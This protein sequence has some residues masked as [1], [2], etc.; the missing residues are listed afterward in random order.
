MR[1]SIGTVHLSVEASNPGGNM[2]IRLV[3]TAVSAV[4]VLVVILGTVS[5]LYAYTVIDQMIYP[6]DG[7]DDEAPGKLLQ[8]PAGSDFQV[9]LDSILASGALGLPGEAVQ[10]V[11]SITYTG[12]DAVRD[13]AVTT[14]LHE[15]LRVDAVEATRGEVSVSGP[16]VVVTAAKLNPGDV[17]AF[18]VDTT[19]LRSP[20]NGRLFN[21]TVLSAAGPT[22]PITGG[23]SAEMYVPTGL[24]ATGYAPDE[25]L[26]GEGEPSVVAVGLMAFSTVA[27]A[28]L[29]VWYRGRKYWF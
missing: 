11:V 9:E 7:I 23:A 27:V 22:G 8:A 15:G 29:F 14:T 10:W 4:V 19:V 5:P 6:G 13:V 18:T 20:A 2:S 16:V 17:L 21:Q 25:G 12:G 3:I 26:P 28:A 24:P 1:A